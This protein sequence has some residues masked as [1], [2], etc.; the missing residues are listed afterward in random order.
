MT[1][2]AVGFRLSEPEERPFSTIVERY[3]DHISEIFFAWQDFPTCRSNT[4]STHGYTDWSIQQKVEQELL[5]FRQMG[6]RLDLVLNGNCY[7]QYAISE[8]LANN[9]CSILDYL[10]DLV[11]IDIVTTASPAIA[12]IVKRKYPDI[13]VRASVNMRIG[14]V[15]GMEYMAEY[16]DS[17]HIQRDYNRDLSHIAQLREWADR[18]GKKLIILA[19]SGCLSFCS[20]QTFHDN[21]V[22][23]ES[24]IC[25]VHNLKD[26]TPY[27][28]WRLFK[29]KENWHYFLENTWIRPEDL[30]HYDSL[31]DT[32]KLATRMHDHPE[33][34]IDAYAKR[35]Y[36]GNLADLFE[37]G[38]GMAFAPYIVDNQR[39]PK[40]WFDTVLNCNKQCHTCGYCKNVMDQV[41]VNTEELMW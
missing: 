17:F 8:R 11:G 1:K 23:H 41:L 6:K 13:E 25:E 40:D 2:F 22:A 10:N 37:P 19:N 31:V 12:H 29:N 21:L 33:L 5:K 24:E 7:G 39:F 34:V 30:H 28:C 15:K 35:K 32:V 16:F 20:G 38:F 27:A 9:V 18:A 14:T 36:Y 4:A 26:F 3:S